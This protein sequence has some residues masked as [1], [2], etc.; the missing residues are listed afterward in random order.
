MAPF[1]TPENLKI[2][3]G[4]LS[5]TLYRLKRKTNQCPEQTSNNKAN[6]SLYEASAA[7]PTRVYAG[8]RFPIAVQP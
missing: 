2:L 1:L 7:E 4:K 3:Q 5:K 6:P 8:R